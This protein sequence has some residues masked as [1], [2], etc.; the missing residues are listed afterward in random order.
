[1]RRYRSDYRG[2]FGSYPDGYGLASQQAVGWLLEA[3]A[4]LKNQGTPITQ[5]ALAEEL[6]KRWGMQ[7]HGPDLYS[8]PVGPPK[9]NDWIRVRE[10]LGCGSKSQDG[11]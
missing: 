3:H 5:K 6:L 7:D 10:V 9:L 2:H 1:M 4:K 8:L 11:S